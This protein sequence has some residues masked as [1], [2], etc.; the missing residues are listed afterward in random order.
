MPAQTRVVERAEKR[1][2]RRPSGL[3]LLTIAETKLREG[4]VRD[5]RKLFRAIV[6]RYPPSL[7]RLA[8]SAYLRSVAS[9]P[10]RQREGQRAAV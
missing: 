5:A 3:L 2:R 1:P 8:A 6:N 10:R 4:N 7:E 9:R